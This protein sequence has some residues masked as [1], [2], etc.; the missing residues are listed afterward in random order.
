MNFK[1]VR[2]PTALQKAQAK[3]QQMSLLSRLVDPAPGEEKLPTHQF[4]ASLAELKRAAPGVTIASIVTAFNLSAGEQTELEGLVNNAYLDKIDRGM[5]HDVLLLGEG[6]QYSLATCQSRL[7]DPPLVIDFWPLITQRA[8]EVVAHGIAGNCVLSGCTV[9]A[10][11]VPN[12]TL[13]VAKGAVVSGNTLRG[14]SAGN[15]SFNTA[16]ATLPRIDLLVVA[17]DG[18]KT[19]RAGTPAARPLPASLVGGDVC[20]AFVSVPP[21]DTAITADQFLDTRVFRNGPIIVGKLTSPIIRNNSATAE[22]FIT[23]TLPNG[24]MVSGRQLRIKCGGTMLLNS[25]T[26]TITLR[27]AFDGTTLFQDVTGAATAD[28]DRLMWDIEFT[29]CAQADND[30]AMVGRLQLSPIGAKTAPTSGAGD[31]AGTAALVNPFGGSS[32]VDVTTA[33][34]DLILQWTMS[35]ANGSNEITMEYATAEL[36]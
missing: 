27:I 12:M 7:Q 9:S 29:L 24:L 26:P 2:L 18:T 6:G 32:A 1:A 31:I 21:V 35:V 4:M 13:A 11:G 17:S 3:T 20:L 14:V 30:Q 22:T 19:A 8:F 36:I 10:Q 33:D 5:L 15:V 23:L 28:A 34:R 25:G 16:H